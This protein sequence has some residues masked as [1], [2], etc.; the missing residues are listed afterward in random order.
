[1]YCRN[2]DL[3]LVPIMKGVGPHVGA[4]CKNCGRWLKWLNKEERELNEK[5][6]RV[7]RGGVP[8]S[9]FHTAINEASSN[10]PDDYP[11]SYPNDFDDGEVPWN[12]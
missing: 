2:C 1:M 5:Y 3:N 9:R 8:Q 12:E 4:Y 6:E 10:L 11:S 7:F